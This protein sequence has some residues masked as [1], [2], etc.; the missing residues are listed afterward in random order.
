MSNLHRAK[1][2]VVPWIGGH[3]CN[4][5]DQCNRGIVA[6]PEDRVTAAKML[7]VSDIFSDEKLRAV[8]IGPGVGISE[9]AGPVKP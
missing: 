7:T 8:G 9:P 4:L 2:A 5:L 6:L 3:T 1:R